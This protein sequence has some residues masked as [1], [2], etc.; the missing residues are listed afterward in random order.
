MTR[1]LLMTIFIAILVR[2]SNAP[3][4]EGGVTY[5]CNNSILTLL[6]ELR[7]APAP[8]WLKPGMRLVWYQAAA[9]IPEGRFGNMVPDP[10]GRWHDPATGMNFRLDDAQ[11]PSG[12]GYTQLD[13][14]AVHDDVVAVDVITY[15]RN[16]MGDEVHIILTDAITTPPG[17][18]GDW[19]VNPNVL[20]R[21]LDINGP[22]VRS[23]RVP[24]KLDG[25]N[26]NSFWLST[27]TSDGSTSTFTDI[28]SGLNLHGGIAAK[29]KSAYVK[30]NGVSTP[31]GGK[32]GLALST[33][34]GSRQLQ[35]PWAGTALPASIANLHK[36]HFR[37]ARTCTVPGSPP[38]P[39]NYI[40]E[41]SIIGRGMDFLQAKRDAAI[42]LGNGFRQS[43]PT[44]N[45]VSGCNQL[46]PL[47]IPPEHLA[48][49]QV[50]QILDRDPVT[51]IVTQVSFVGR[52]RTGRD[53]VE[54]TLSQGEGMFHAV[55]VYD[56]TTGLLAGQAI[57][58][59]AAFTRLDYVVTGTE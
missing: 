40:G 1:R 57:V 42:D 9:T 56:R 52:N 47:A 51:K 20:D 38:L 18:C 59:P 55:Y 16:G 12:H 54:L 14:I 8:G 15:G 19:W 41:I 23:A 4:Q 6:P 21:H 11:G 36:L 31:I 27:I 2:A 29:S 39:I 45:M 44:V 22:G 58:D 48:R 32:T 49:L 33:F 3:A 24:Y 17:Y 26:Y 30:L 28:K 5:H 35:I 50:G 53:V 13:V 43:E 34:R 7:N 37:G 46:T 25:T 10:K